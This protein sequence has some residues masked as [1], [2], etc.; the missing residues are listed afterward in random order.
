VSA[1]PATLFE[2]TKHTYL[3]DMISLRTPAEARASVRKLN[4]EFLGAVTDAKRLRITRA[5]RLAANRAKVMSR[6][7]RISGREQK[8]FREIFHIYDDASDRA[9]RLYH[10]SKK[11][12][13]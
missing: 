2:P 4:F 7:S 5:I 13:Q 11:V 3:G 10:K 6:S 12:K 9:F 8:E 1:K